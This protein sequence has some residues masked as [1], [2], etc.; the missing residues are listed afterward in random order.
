MLYLHSIVLYLFHL[1]H[2]KSN[3][4]GQ[5]FESPLNS[6]SSRDRD[7]RLISINHRRWRTANISKFR[8]AVVTYKHN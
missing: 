6:R 8:E 4:I 2:Y 7:T 3:W 5:N 1:T